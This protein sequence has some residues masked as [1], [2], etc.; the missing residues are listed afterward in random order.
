MLLTVRVLEAG[1]L[2]KGLGGG[3][4]WGEGG[5]MGCTLAPY[6]AGKIPL[7]RAWQVMRKNPVFPRK[8]NSPQISASVPR[9]LLLPQEAP[10]R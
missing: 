1:M 7:L 3:A 9:F 5:L 2:Q 6:A 4:V 8:I 10:G